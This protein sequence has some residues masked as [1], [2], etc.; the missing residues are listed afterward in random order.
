M[1]ETEN[2]HHVITIDIR[3]ADSPKLQIRPRHRVR[4][5]VSPKRAVARHI[6]RSHAVDPRRVLIGGKA[7]P[8][9]LDRRGGGRG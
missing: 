5:L 2:T 7:D 3:P 1:K 6:A 8:A 4:A 9:G